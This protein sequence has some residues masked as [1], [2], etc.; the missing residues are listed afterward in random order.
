MPG[1]CSLKASPPPPHR[2]YESIMLLRLA[3]PTPLILHKLGFDAELV[4]KKKKT[5]IIALRGLL[6]IQGILTKLLLMIKLLT[7]P[8]VEVSMIP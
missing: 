5:E 7:S 8:F 4:L 3:K 2:R 1:Q 6:Y